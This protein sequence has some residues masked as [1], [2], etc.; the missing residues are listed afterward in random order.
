VT[1]RAPARLRVAFL[2]T[3]SSNIHFFAT[4]ASV[5]VARSAWVLRH[6][7][8]PDLLAAVG[9]GTEAKEH[10]F[11]DT[12]RE[13]RSL[14]EDAD[15]V[16]LTCSSL[17]PACEGWPEAPMSLLRADAELARAVTSSGGR[18]LAL[19]A[20]PSS[21]QATTRI[22]QAAAAGASAKV[23][24]RLVAGAW[25][26]FL[27]GRHDAYEAA[28]AQEVVAA[29]A[30]YDAIALAQTSM[31]A[32]VQRLD[33]DMPVRT[34]PDAVMARLDALSTETSAVTG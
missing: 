11:Q 29:H 2:H 32:A 13:L 23:E 7:V 1:A 5:S 4:A 14:A 19:Y 28:I 6:E 22:F 30:G 25:D 10:A 34:I 15:A 31:A 18:V 24:C 16:V 9:G 3:A 33:P 8:R 12:R 20:A 17:G 26:H 21:E 27:A